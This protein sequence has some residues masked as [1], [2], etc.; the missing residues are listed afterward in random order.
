MKKISNEMKAELM[1][2]T[3]FSVEQLL[4]FA[5]AC[6]TNKCEGMRE[7]Y[8][9]FGDAEGKEHY[10]RLSKAMGILMNVLD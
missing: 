5:L 6:A 8:E 4:R 7:A 3:G 1:E 9:S 2:L 10:E